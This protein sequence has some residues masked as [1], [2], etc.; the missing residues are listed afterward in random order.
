MS[1][2]HKK[3]N[4]F[5]LNGNFTYFTVYYHW[6]SFNFCLS[7]LV[8]IPIGVSSSVVGL[9]ICAIAPRIKK[10]KSIIKKKRKNHDKLALL[11][12]TNLNTTQSFISKVS[13][14]SYINHEKICF[15]E[16]YVM[17]IWW[18]KEAIKNPSVINS[19]NL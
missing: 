4:E 1:K 3:L 12:K 2:K 19:D 17:I 11:A 5:K 15:S 16:K 18:H 10:N 9:K 14:D 7:L 13:V 8:D 6:I